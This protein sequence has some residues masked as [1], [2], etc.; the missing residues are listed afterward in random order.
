M[1]QFRFAVWLLYWYMR[2]NPFSFQCDEGN[3]SKNS[4]KH[5]LERE[6]IESV[7]YLKQAIPLGEQV[8]PQFKELRLCVVGPSSRDR[9]I[10]VVFTLREKKIRAISSRV[11]SKKERKIYEEIRKTIENV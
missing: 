2:G 8:R 5:G 11:A 6:E 1:A 3:S 10:S 4:L 7:F 9:M